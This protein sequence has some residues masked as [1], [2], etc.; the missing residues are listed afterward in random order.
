MLRC[1]SGGAARG[2]CAGQARGTRVPC[3]SGGPAGARGLQSDLSAPRDCCQVSSSTNL[4]KPQRLQS[5]R[6]GSAAASHTPADNG[7][8]EGRGRR[9]GDPR[10]RSTCTVPAAAALQIVSLHPQNKG[11]GAPSVPGAGEGA[12]LAA[13]RVQREPDK[14]LSPADASSGEI[15][16]H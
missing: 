3:F 6:G 15:M 7:A 4:Q 9:P 13:R 5:S 1:F 12:A 16:K 11:P 2:S 14:G 8:Q 10:A